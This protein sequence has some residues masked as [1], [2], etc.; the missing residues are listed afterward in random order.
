MPTGI[1]AARVDDLDRCEYDVLV[2]E[3]ERVLPFAFI[4]FDPEA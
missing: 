3:A 4:H 2:L 1:Q